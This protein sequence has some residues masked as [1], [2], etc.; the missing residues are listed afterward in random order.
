MARA[1]KTAA[2][3]EDVKYEAIE[4]FSD[5]ED[6]G[7]VYFAGD[8]YPKPANKI[9]PEERLQVLLSKNNKKKRPVIKEV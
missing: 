2:T 1:K 9:I 8:R 7:K 4:D 3:K 5:L 6:G